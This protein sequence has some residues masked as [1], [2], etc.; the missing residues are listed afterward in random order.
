MVPIQV[1]QLLAAF[2]GII[3][4]PCNSADVWDIEVSLE[5]EQS[6]PFL[7]GHITVFK[8]KTDQRYFI[9]PLAILR[10]ETAESSFNYLTDKYEMKFDVEMI[11][12]EARTVVFENLRGKDKNITVDSVELLPTEKLR[13]VWN[14]QFEGLNKNLTLATN[15]ISNSGLK[16]SIAFKFSCANEEVC[17]K[18][19][20]WMKDRPQDFSQLELQF[21]L[22]GQTS[23]TKKL[24]VTG[25]LISKGIS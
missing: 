12:K 5:T 6:V 7:N 1:I 20:K 10:E 16:K 21:V 9:A 13:L 25:E 3:F 24:T 4:E 17:K 8:H 19:E 22:N 11:S 15:W 23:S 18:L 14:N 2:A